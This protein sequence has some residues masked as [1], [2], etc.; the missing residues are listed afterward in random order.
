[1]R[2]FTQE[3]K[4]ELEFLVRTKT[5]IRIID[6]SSY[7]DLVESLK[8]DI[9]QANTCID[10]FYSVTDLIQAGI[11]RLSDQAKTDLYA[12]VISDSMMDELKKNY[13]DVYNAIEDINIKMSNIEITQTLKIAENTSNRIVTIT[14]GEVISVVM[15][16]ETAKDIIK[17]HEEGY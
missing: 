12:R 14:A 16:D 17:L 11:M 13:Q 3:R 9:N 10:D 4:E 15:D 7:Y 5:P 8:I 1:M 2:E 6:N